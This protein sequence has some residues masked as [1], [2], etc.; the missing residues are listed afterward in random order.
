MGLRQATLACALAAMLLAC[1]PIFAQQEELYGTWR[2]VSWTRELVGSSE[3]TDVFGK[4]PRGFIA[5]GRDGRMSVIVVREN[6]PK[7]ADIAKLTDADRAQLFG[8]MVAYAG[9]FKVEGSRVTH[10]VDISWN[11]NWTGTAQLRNVRIDG[12]RLII[13]SDPQPSSV[14]G[15]MNTVVLVWEKI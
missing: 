1:P 6:R 4:S 3:R 14:D 7:P 11:E 12:R 2:L 9:T 13:T 5:Y 8:S 15:K 10:N